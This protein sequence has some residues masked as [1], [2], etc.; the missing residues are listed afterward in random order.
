MIDINLIRD[1]FELVK[2]NIKKKFQ[3]EKLV[4]VDE[5][6]EMDKEYRASKTKGD[7][8]RAERN[9]ISKTI[10]GLMTRHLYVELKAG[11]EVALG[12]SATGVE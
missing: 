1:N 7:S 11:M 2:E 3:D 5:V 10:G 4:L 9:R 8:L 12:I 6:F